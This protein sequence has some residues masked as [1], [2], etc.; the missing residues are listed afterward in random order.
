MIIPTAEY[1]PMF[2]DDGVPFRDKMIDYILREFSDTLGAQT[3]LR[4]RD[5]LAAVTGKDVLIANET[6]RQSRAA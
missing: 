3:G 4:R 1:D 6:P 2:A 5:V